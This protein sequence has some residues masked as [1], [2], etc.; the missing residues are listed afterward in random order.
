MS[1]QEE[2]SMSHNINR[3]WRLANR[4]KGMV[5]ETDFAY[6]EAPIPELQAGQFLVRNLYIAFAPAMRGLLRDRRGLLRDRQSQIATVQI[7]EV[8]RASCVG[9]VVASRHPD[10]HPGDFVR[11][12]FGWQ[13]YMA[14]SGDGMRPTTKL[15][16]SVP[17]TMPLSVLGN[18]GLTAYFGLLDIGRPQAGDTVVVSGAAGATGSIAGQI[19]KIHGCRVIGI[20]GG[21]EK[22]AWLAGEAGFDAAI[23]YKAEPV[24]QKLRQLCPEGINIFFDNVGG[25][26]LDAALAVIAMQACIV[27]CGGISRYNEET[28]SPGP[29]NYFNLVLQR[30]RMEGFNTLDYTPRFAEAEH[31]LKR[32]ITAGTLKYKEDIQEGF[33][34]APKTLLRLF[35][36]KNFGKQLLKIADPPLGGTS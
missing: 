32:W 12:T 1:V 22:C 31:A 27:L 3:Q 15:A 25:D 7:G 20:A 18:T 33:M 16:P 9:Q 11:G 29:K 26:I 35:E 34:N 10:F 2:D 5:Q 21:P 28:L 36:G 8:M 23:D 4:P 6:H 14:T 13:D 19:A 17:L 24:E 30:G